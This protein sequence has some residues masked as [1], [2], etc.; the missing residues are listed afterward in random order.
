[1]AIPALIHSDSIKPKMRLRGGRALV[2]GLA[3]LAA[4]CATTAGEDSALT[5]IDQV[6]G[7]WEHV[8]RRNF[9]PC[10]ARVLSMCCVGRVQADRSRLRGRRLQH[11]GKVRVERVE[12]RGG[13]GRQEIFLSTSGK[14]LATVFVSKQQAPQTWRQWG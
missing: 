10:F 2:L 6:G 8:C 12:I 1:M 5:T 9:S 7:P 11:V 3:V 13:S 14:R 4:L